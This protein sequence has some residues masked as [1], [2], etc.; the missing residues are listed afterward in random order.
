MNICI[1]RNYLYD[2]WDS[3]DNLVLVNRTDNE[4][5]DEA[6]IDE[7]KMFR[8]KVSDE[9][10]IKTDWLYKFLRK[11]SV[12]IMTEG[13]DGKFIKCLR[14]GELDVSMQLSYR[15]CCLRSDRDPNYYRIGEDGYK[16]MTEE[17]FN[18]LFPDGEYSDTYVDICIWN[19][20]TEKTYQNATQANLREID[21]FLRGIAYES[22]MDCLV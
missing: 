10:E 21:K 3:D 13:G 17:E 19:N 9:H 5:L 2:E 18:S 22:K 4:Y 20:V 16:P 1:K 11:N 6:T 12:G 7:I 14:L 15:L 8:G